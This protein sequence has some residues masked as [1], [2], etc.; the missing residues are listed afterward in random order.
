MKILELL[1]KEELISNNEITEINILNHEKRNV[2]ES[3]RIKYM[4]NNGSCSNLFIKAIHSEKATC[5]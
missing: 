4:A 5:E 3:Y 1:I 2:S